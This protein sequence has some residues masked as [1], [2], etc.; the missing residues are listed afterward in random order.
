MRSQA[1]L[2]AGDWVEV[3]S[4]EEIFR[5]LGDDACLENMP[6]MPEM[7]QYC[8]RRFRVFKR[9][10]RTCDT[11]D[12]IGGRHLKRS[13]HLEGLRCNGSAHGDCQ[14]LCLLFWKESWLEKVE[15]PDTP[16]TVSL[17][18]PRHAENP[19][20]NDAGV[21]RG[22][23]RAGEPSDCSDPTYVCQATKLLDA[24]FPLRRSDLEPYVEDLT[25]R[26]VNVRQMLG[27][28]AF[29]MF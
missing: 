24:T 28:F 9:A 5:T 25:S 19:G 15:G 2:R 20:S 14:A 22:T 16:G 23:R 21:W 6:F 7:L 4:R 12:Y 17:H 13:V 18:H 10:H 8:G 1:K 26:N 3:R 11:V 27:R 29:V